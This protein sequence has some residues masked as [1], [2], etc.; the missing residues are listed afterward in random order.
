MMMGWILFAMILLEE[1]KIKITWKKIIVAILG[2]IIYS[3]A[4]KYLIGTIKTLCLCILYVIMFRTIFKTT[5]Y[6]AILLTF[7]YIVLMMVPDI[8]FTVIIILGE[9]AQIFYAEYAKTII[10]TL[11]VNIMFV[12][13][14]YAS[15]KWLRKLLKL[16]TNINKEMIVYTILTLGCVLVIFY[17]ATTEIKVISENFGLSILVMLLFVVVLYSLL[18]QRLENKKIEEKYDKLL[19]F[20][21]KYEVVIE[22]Q[23]AVRHESKNQLITIKARIVNKVGSEK[24]IEYIDSL[25]SDYKSSDEEKY[26]KFQYLPANGIKG[27]FYYKAMEAEEKGIKL[28]IR[29]AERVETSIL[30]EL[31]TED[32]KQLGRLI[33]V[34]LDNAIEASGTSEEKKL[35]IE[36]YKH[37]KD[38]TIIISNTYSGVIDTES[39]GKVKY[40]TKGTGRGYG[41]ML[42][43]KILN[44]NKRFVSNRIVTDTLYIQKLVIKAYN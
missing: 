4:I 10:A 22:E 24:V 40:S 12:L 8:I 11:V 32:F 9:S 33:G 18:R 19:E 28:S 38:V 2:I 42:V 39:V 15:K 30:S 34:Y 13:M 5:Y 36:I 17:N 43:K 16:G 14:I 21:K 26:G 29:V 27:L 6:D 1:K 37:K 7:M 35:G 44:E 20:I 23:K 31:S 41:L 3:L 25:L